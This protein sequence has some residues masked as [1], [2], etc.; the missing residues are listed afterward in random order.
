MTHIYAV[1]PSMRC[2]YF[3]AACLLALALTPV[4][5]AER[6]TAEEYQAKAALI[7]KFAKFVNWPADRLEGAKSPFIIAV[8]GKIPIRDSL[9]ALAGKRIDGRSVEIRAYPDMSYFEPCHVLFC[10]L[11]DMQ[12]F[13]QAQIRL[14][15]DEHVLTVGDVHG[16]AN[17][18]GILSLTFV[19]DHLAFRVNIAAAQRAGLVIDS[20]V[21]RL[22]IEV[23]D[24]SQ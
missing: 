6:I 20:N 12:R 22:A 15:A 17:A 21:L 19:D 16:F 3:A 10:S 9:K 8:L 5:A 2:G 14:L 24:D 7:Y 13:S 11:G 1:T 4:G 18:G 23:I